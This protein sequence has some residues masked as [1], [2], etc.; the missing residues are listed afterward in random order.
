M[1][2]FNLWNELNLPEGDAAWGNETGAWFETG[3]E[4]CLGVVVV[5]LKVLA[6]TLLLEDGVVCWEGVGKEAAVVGVNE[7]VVC[8]MFAVACKG[9]AVLI[10]IVGAFKWHVWIFGAICFISSK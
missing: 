10:D 2:I 5:E 9:V 1:D 8:A 4:I 6:W 7:A 3:W